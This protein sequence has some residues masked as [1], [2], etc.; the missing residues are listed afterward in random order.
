[1]VGYLEYFGGQELAIGCHH[2]HIR[3][4]SRQ[5]LVR[6]RIPQASGLKQTYPIIYT[7][8]SDWRGSGDTTSS[9]WSVRLGADTDNI[10][11]GDER[12][13]RRYYVF[14]RTHKDNSHESLPP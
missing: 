9:N 6:N 1:M 7:V 11:C 4:Q 14:R 8:P 10:S 2:N 3:L 12:L 5:F 13:E